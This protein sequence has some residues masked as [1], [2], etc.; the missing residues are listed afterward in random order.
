M[1]QLLPPS[2]QPIGTTVPEYMPDKTLRYSAWMGGAV[3][4]KV[5]QNACPPTADVDALIDDSKVRPDCKNKSWC[6]VHLQFCSRKFLRRLVRMM[7]QSAVLGVV[8]DV[9][10]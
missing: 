10:Q 9:E 6:V 1:R 2:L 7:V 5:F 8:Q 3:L 4:S